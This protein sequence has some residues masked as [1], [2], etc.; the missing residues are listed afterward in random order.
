V[1]PMI[2]LVLIRGGWRL[3]DFGGRPGW[4]DLHAGILLWL[5][6]VATLGIVHVLAQW[7]F[8]AEN[9][10]LRQL[11]DP[12]AAEAANGWLVAATF[13]VNPF[14]EELL[15]TVYVV[16]AL[17]RRFSTSTAVHVSALLR[18]VY[19]LYQGPYAIVWF[20]VYGLLAAHAY[21][22]WRSVWP[23]VIAHILHDLVALLLTTSP[24][25]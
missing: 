2:A 24:A 23:L 22:R 13:L 19:H 11:A 21:M 14:F 6:G 25:L 5:A 4:R 8:G 20:G 17:K 9:E 16:E 1:L 18:M 10:A 3:A 15:V 12:R 7:L